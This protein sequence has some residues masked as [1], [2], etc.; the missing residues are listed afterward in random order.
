MTNILKSN[1]EEVKKEHGLNKNDFDVFA[2]NLAISFKEY[3]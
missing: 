3:P 2:D 1:I